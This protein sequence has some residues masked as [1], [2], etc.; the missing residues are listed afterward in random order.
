MSRGEP[1]GRRRVRWQ[2]VLPQSTG[3]VAGWALGA[4]LPSRGT[5][6][7]SSSRPSCGETP[8]AP[9]PRPHLLCTCSPAAAALGAS[10]TCLPCPGIRATLGDLEAHVPTMRASK[11]IGLTNNSGLLLFRG[12]KKS[13]SFSRF[14]LNQIVKRP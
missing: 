7:P 14:E 5:E 12:K 3:G 13:W 11:L 6:L 4:P 2:S 8:A 9:R 1:N 10:D